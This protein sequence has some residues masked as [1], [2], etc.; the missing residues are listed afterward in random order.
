[1]LPIRKPI[2]KTRHHYS[3]RKKMNAL[4]KISND[5]KIYVWPEDAIQ[6]NDRLNVV[7]LFPNKA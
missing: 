3:L 7:T 2:K 6:K 4:K 1:M 5:K